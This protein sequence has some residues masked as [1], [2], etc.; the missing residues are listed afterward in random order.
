MMNYLDHQ[1]YHV[2]NRGA[3]KGKLFFS[4][5]NDR[6]CLRLVEKYRKIYQVSIVCY[7]LM[8]NHYHFI[9]QQESGGS[10][11]RFLQMT[12]N[13]YTQ[14]VNREQRRSGTMSQGRAKGLLVDDDKYLVQLVRYIHLNPVVAGL[15]AKPEEWEF[16]DYENWITPAEG[17]EIRRM[18]FPDSDE[19]KSFVEEYKDERDRD[20][21]TKYIVG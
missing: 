15:V 10:I 7:C 20:L 19:Y 3:H 17:P 21:L 6:Y 8:P 11:S 4:D 18:Y 1:Y 5:E 14:A 9:L 12:F 13:A 2:Y 16:S